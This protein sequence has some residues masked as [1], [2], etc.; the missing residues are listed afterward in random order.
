MGLVL[1]H[2]ERTKSGGFRYRRRVPR[3]VG[4]IIAKREFKRKLGLTEAEALAAWPRYHAQVE[5][6]IDNARKRLALA[7][8]L[9]NGNASEREA[10]AEAL[11]RRADLISSGVDMQGDDPALIADSLLAGYPEN[12]FGPV[13]V[14]PVDRHLVNLLRNGPDRHKAPDPTLG[15]ALKLYLKEHLRED[16]P[17]TDSRVIGL[18][19]RVI[20]SAI[21]AMRRDPIL[22]TITREDARNV[23]DLSLI[24]I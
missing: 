18:A 19:K 23:R 21:G 22:T 1:R 12:A 4:G 16:D 7:D 2:V 11:R 24:H 3:D 9:A 13:G 17:E 20:A 10:Y 5:R 6:E 14:P 15:D 8:T